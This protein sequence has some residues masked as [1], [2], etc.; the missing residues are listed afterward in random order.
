[1][2]IKKSVNTF[3]TEDTSR[4]TEMPEISKEEWKKQLQRVMDLLEYVDMDEDLKEDIMDNLI[5]VETM[6]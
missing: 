6:I 4:G 5:T 1:M 3:I 2:A